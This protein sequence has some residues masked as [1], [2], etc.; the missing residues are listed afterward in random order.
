MHRLRLRDEGGFSLI[1]MVAVM[2]ILGIVL[3]GITT[4]FITGSRTELQVNNRFQAQ[5]AARLAMAAVRKD[6]HGA[7]AASVTGTNGSVLTLSIATSA[8]SLTKDNCGT[9]TGMTKVIWTVCT[10]PTVSTKY[11]LYRATVSTC[12]ST[13]GKLVAD[14]LILPASNA[15]FATAASSTVSIPLGEWQTVDVDMRASLKQGTAGQPFELQ[16]R[17]A[18]SNGVWITSQNTACSASGQC[19]PGPCWPASPCYVPSIS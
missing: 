11:A 19:S 7:C 14:N 18:V 8:A 4:V 6:T 13:T 17:L 15:F 3:A 10:S 16:E 5:E 1:E 12:P 2:A 9:A